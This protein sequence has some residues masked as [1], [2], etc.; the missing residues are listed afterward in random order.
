MSHQF[1]F[2]FLQ[3][4][5]VAQTSVKSISLTSL[6]LEGLFSGAHSSKAD[7]EKSFC[8]AICRPQSSP[9][10]I[11]RFI[12]VFSQYKL[13]PQDY[14]WVPRSY[15]RCAHFSRDF[16]LPE[17]SF[18]SQVTIFAVSEWVYVFSQRCSLSVW[19]VSVLN[20]YL[21]SFQM[22]ANI[23]NSPAGF[24]DITKV[25]PPISPVYC[26]LPPQFFYFLWF[27]TVWGAITIN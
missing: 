15:T 19:G 10:I 24:S 9:N 26:Q 5:R 14:C 8:T 23:W 1:T 17:L 4:A 22:K 11:V 18:F 12:V 7:G 13:V 25:L 20:S 2:I 27:L 6:G 3:G 16:T 21:C